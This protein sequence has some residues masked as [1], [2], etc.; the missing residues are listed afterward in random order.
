M[1]PAG[2]TASDHTPVGFLTFGQVNPQSSAISL[3][4]HEAG[5]RWIFLIE[6]TL[7]PAFRNLG[8]GEREKF[9]SF[10]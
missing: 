3:I 1:K 7:T 6:R 10:I 2:V 9:K 4:G 5:E 8:G